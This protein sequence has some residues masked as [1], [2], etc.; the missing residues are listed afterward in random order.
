MR[1][2]LQ[3]MRVASAVLLALLLAS[4]GVSQGRQEQFAAA[5]I[6]APPPGVKLPRGQGIEVRYRAFMQLWVAPEDAEGPSELL[7]VDYI[8]GGR[9]IAHFW[10]PAAEGRY[11]LI[12]VAS[13]VKDARRDATPAG[14]LCCVTVLP[15]GAPV[16]LD[17]R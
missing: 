6:I 15:A 1:R 12:V 13:E 7:A 14:A 4:A 9:E 2:W 8:R 5:S 17:R 10:S 11:C 16:S 3:A